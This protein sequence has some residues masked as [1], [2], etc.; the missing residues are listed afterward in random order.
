MRGL[1]KFMFYVDGGGW[2]RA[3]SWNIKREL[4]HTKE[5][6]IYKFINKKSMLS[7]I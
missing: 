7:S 4:I 3:F 5:L 1:Q 6:G 2:G